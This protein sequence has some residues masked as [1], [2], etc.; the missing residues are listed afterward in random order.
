M[1]SPVKQLQQRR[2]QRLEQLSRQGYLTQSQSEEYV[3]LL[4]KQELLEFIQRQ[5]R[6]MLRAVGRQGNL[7]FSWQDWLARSHRRSRGHHVV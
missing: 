3:S 1:P 4:T 7:T 6:E 5:H 2:K